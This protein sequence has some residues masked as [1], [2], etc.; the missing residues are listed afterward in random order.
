MAE[1]GDAEDTEMA[2][3]ELTYRLPSAPEPEYQP[4]QPPFARRI[5]EMALKA[6]RILA[7]AMSHASVYGLAVVAHAIYDDER[8]YRG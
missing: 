6:G 4:P 8:R 7:D 5:G 2:E 3:L 1:F